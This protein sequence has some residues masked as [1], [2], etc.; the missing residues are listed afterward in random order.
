MASGNQLQVIEYSA[1]ATEEPIYPHPL[2]ELAHQKVANVVLQPTG[3]ELR[4]GQ[5]GKVSSS[6]GLRIFENERG[7]LA[8]IML[9]G[10]AEHFDLSKIYYVGAA[11]QLI[12]EVRK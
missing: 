9:R 12:I 10:N 4:L 8:G 5:K 11:F 3:G 6:V 2:G 1:T 7:N